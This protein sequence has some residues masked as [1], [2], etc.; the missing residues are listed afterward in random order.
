MDAFEFMKQ[1]EKRRS[2]E[3]IELAAKNN[4]PKISLQ[5]PNLPPI[6]IPET[7]NAADT[8]D[9]LETQRYNAENSRFA[10]SVDPD[11]IYT[12]G[13]I[14]GERH[15]AHK[16]LNL[17]TQSDS[18]YFNDF[19]TEGELN[20]K[21]GDIWRNNIN[22]KFGNRIEEGSVGDWM[23]HA[24]AKG[25]NVF[26]SIGLFGGES[27]DEAIYESQ[28]DGDLPDLPEDQ[29]FYEILVSGKV[30]DFWPEDQRENLEQL[31]S[32]YRSDPD[33]TELVDLIHPDA[34][35]KQQRLIQEVANSGQER[36]DILA[37][38]TGNSALNLLYDLGAGITAA[39]T[40]SPVD[41]GLFF[42]PIAP[43]KFVQGAKITAGVVK[44]TRNL[45][46]GL[47][48][49][50]SGK[51]RIRRFLTDYEYA[52]EAV[53]L[54][55]S[56]A[57]IDATAAGVILVPQA[58]AD[59][60]A[61]IDIGFDKE[62]R[63][64][65]DA[66]MNRM[67]EILFVGGI[68]GASSL[69][70]DGIKYP[71]W[72][73]TT[74]VKSITDDAIIT[75]SKKG[76]TEIQYRGGK[77]EPE[78]L[79]I[80]GHHP[81]HL[82]DTMNPKTEYDNTSPIADDVPD[83]QAVKKENT[84]GIED[85]PYLDKIDETGGY[86]FDYDAETAKIKPIQKEIQEL[87]KKHTNRHPGDDESAILLDLEYK[88]AELADIQNSQRI[89]NH[90]KKHLAEGGSASKINKAIKKYNED[91]D[92]ENGKEQRKL[93]K[94]IETISASK[95]KKSDA[96]INRN[97]KQARTDYENRLKDA[98]K[99]L[100][101]DIETTF[102]IV[103]DEAKG[104]PG[105]S[106]RAEFRDAQA[107]LTAK[108]NDTEI[109]DE[110][111]NTAIK[112]AETELREVHAEIDIK[113]KEK[114]A[115][116]TNDKDRRLI[117]DGAK[118]EKLLRSEKILLKYQLNMLVDKLNA[119]IE[120][121]DSVSPA[122]AKQYEK[123]IKKVNALLEKF[124]GKKVF[125]DIGDTTP[126]SLIKLLKVKSDAMLERLK[127][128]AVKTVEVMRG[129]P[130]RE[131]PMRKGVN[132][133]EAIEVTDEAAAAGQELK[134]K[135]GNIVMKV[136]DSENLDEIFTSAYADDPIYRVGHS[137]GSI[138]A[139]FW[140]WRRSEFSADGQ[141]GPKT[142]VRRFKGK[143]KN[144]DIVTFVKIV[145]DI[146]D[147]V[148]FD[149][150]NQFS[151]ENVYLDLNAY[152]DSNEKVVTLIF[153]GDTQIYLTPDS[154]VVINQANKRDGII[155]TLEMEVRYDERKIQMNRKTYAADD[156]KGVKSLK[157]VFGSETKREGDL[158]ILGADSNVRETSSQMMSGL[159]QPVIQRV[160]G[161]KLE[162]LR[163]TKDEDFRDV[164]DNV[165]KCGKT[166]VG[167]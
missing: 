110:A 23:L 8:P 140:N 74:K 165:L 48:Q 144:G 15:Y 56:H 58:A 33:V 113:T 128:G 114:L 28:T 59:R 39:G 161:D 139:P 88:Y 109:V 27:Y 22:K 129:A 65:R 35:N 62:H 108:H 106:K 38:E 52:K 71:F 157:D 25:R 122:L 76:T 5:A 93:N 4:I 98:R 123:E 31:Q 160:K 60:N 66:Y 147:D 47:T 124:Q 85:F 87:E 152:T 72:N 37:R 100:E 2:E 80:A 145:H 159:P 101:D 55:G 77:W 83:I 17:A 153:K 99:K 136:T 90:L 117:K 1:E 21:I 18:R 54:A 44:Q 40:T 141:V 134:Q 150:K 64:V 61:L 89:F 111:V 34:R 19:G 73:K 7:I 26:K 10:R 91:F 105:T 137:K 115:K 78:V 67:L 167:R 57:A 166:K 51:G 6:K 24:W 96:V 148:T 29:D 156:K 43:V 46:G 63:L 162:V 112:Q 102:K 42:L 86:R 138:E 164:I 45:P 49:V 155:E 104:I 82:A 142:I 41:M 143:D 70:L 135:A 14:F 81:E 84:Y 107:F 127:A 79:E 3:K 9:T 163:L 126:A 154:H 75:G 158:Q 50:V 116:A 69:G 125:G 20:R 11:D 36:L 30:P 32:R 16:D 97:I 68:R 92:I 95:G 12:K 118:L 121:P 53:K 13:S 149:G 130:K 132:K 151:R 131:A 119:A 103:D 146:S 94:K 133:Y 120:N